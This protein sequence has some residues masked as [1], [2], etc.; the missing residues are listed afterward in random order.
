MIELP[1]RVARPKRRYL[2]RPSAANQAGCHA[3]G[4]TIGTRSRGEND[5]INET[6]NLFTIHNRRT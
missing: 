3:E 2:R 6:A 4:M 5:G 1:D